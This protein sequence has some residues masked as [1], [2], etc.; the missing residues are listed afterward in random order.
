[1]TALLIYLFIALG[2]SFLCSIAEAVLLSTSTAFISLQEQKGKPVATLLKKLKNDIDSPLAAILSLNTI[3]HT[4]GAAGVGAQAAVVFGSQ[5]LGVISAILTLLILIVSE[6][7]PKTLGSYYWRK[8]AVPT[9]YS[10]K[11]LI[12]GL[13]PLVWFSKVLTRKLKGNSSLK[14]F[15]REEFAAM[16]NL[17]EQEGQLSVHEA[18][19]LQNLF[20]LRD[21]KVTDILTPKTVMFSLP[22][23]ISVTNFVREHT[24]S[25]FSR[26]PIYKDDPE[27]IQGFVLRSDILSADIQGKSKEPL[28]SFKRD[29]IS[30]VDKTTVLSAFEVFVTKKNQ[31]ALVVNEYGVIRGIVTLED[32]LETLTGLEFVDEDDKIEDMQTLARAKWRKRAHDLGLD[33][34][35]ID[36]L[37]HKT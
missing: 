29:I 4:M 36:S 25:K 23:N 16:A 15:S 10:L 33:P 17:G 3:A 28:H 24:D 34:D 1:M 8:L 9:A 26:I 22:E 7:I 5:Y 11:Y 6:I 19:V 35:Q 20:L 30:L 27:N 2:F 13:Y 14:G 18:S 32:I 12:I 21:A 37:N 31:F